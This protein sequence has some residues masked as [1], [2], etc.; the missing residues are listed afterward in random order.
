MWSNLIIFTARGNLINARFAKFS[1]YG[2]YMSQI[3]TLFYRQCA[4]FLYQ[5]YLVILYYYFLKGEN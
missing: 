2:E 3:R 5:K 1:V 4:Y